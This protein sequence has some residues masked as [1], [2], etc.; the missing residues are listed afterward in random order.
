MIVYKYDKNGY[1]TGEHTCQKGIVGEDLFP[2]PPF[3]EVSPL[4]QE[5]GKL[6]KF[7][8][9]SWENVDDNRGKIIYSK[10]D[11]SESICTSVEIESEYTD[12]K[13]NT[14][15]DSWNGINWETN[16]EDYKNNK[17]KNLKVL[18]QLHIEK[19]Y[20]QYKQ[21]NTINDME[22]SLMVLSDTINEDIGN[23]KKL[24]A[25]KISTNDLSE[26]LTIKNNVTL[27]DISDILSIN[28]NKADKIKEESENVIKSLVSYLQILIIR[29]MSNAIEDQYNS[30]TTVEEIDNILVE[31][32]EI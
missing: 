22:Y 16:I 25:S 14:D 30:C 2:N 31:Y 23:V 8:N 13:P 6:L 19:S 26:L 12:I 32:P 10:Q 18:T 21:I 17:I 7:Y 15:F 9:G 11:G 28:A 24:L 29:K 20:P 3:T 4:K 1:F 27:I 5:P